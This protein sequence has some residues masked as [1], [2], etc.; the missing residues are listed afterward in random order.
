MDYNLK[1]A[2]YRSIKFT[3]KFLHHPDILKRVGSMEGMVFHS[4]T[5]HNG[6]QKYAKLIVI[7]CML[8]WEILMF[9]LFTNLV[10]IILFNKKSVSKL[11]NLS[12]S[13]KKLWYYPNLYASQSRNYKFNFQWWTCAEKFLKKLYYI[14]Y[15]IANIMHN[16][17]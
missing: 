16:F 6:I 4:G 1:F 17:Y 7:F 8:S 10:L 11:I 15:D 9:L 12:L 3:A 13:I 5:M 14:G 2:A